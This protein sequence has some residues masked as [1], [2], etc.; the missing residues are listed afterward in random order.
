M[1]ARQGDSI[2]RNEINPLSVS[3][4]R[5]ELDD[6]LLSTAGILPGVSKEIIQGHPQQVRI[7]IG[8]D[9]AGGGGIL[10]IRPSPY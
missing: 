10:G 2:V 5:A 4:Q 9:S 7:S 6:C 3:L 8:H 1:P